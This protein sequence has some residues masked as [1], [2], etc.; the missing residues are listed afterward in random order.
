MF[1]NTFARVLGAAPVATP[2]NVPT[3][4]GELACR[5]PSV[6]Q[7]FQGGRRRVSIE[8]ARQSTRSR[9]SRLIKGGG[10]APSPTVKQKVSPDIFEELH[11]PFQ[12][13]A[14]G[15]KADLKQAA[16]QQIAQNTFPDQVSEYEPE[17]L[18]KT[19]D[20]L[21]ENPLRCSELIRHLSPERLYQFLLEHPSLA[22]H[23][24]ALYSL[25]ERTR[26]GQDTWLRKLGDA[27]VAINVMNTQG[28]L[29]TNGHGVFD[30]AS[31]YFYFYYSLQG[32]A[33]A[34][35]QMGAAFDSLKTFFSDHLQF[36]EAL[37]E[38]RTGKAAPQLN[39][40]AIFQMPPEW[41]LP[42]FTPATVSLET[43]IENPELE[44]MAEADDWILPKVNLLAEARD[45]DAEQIAQDVIERLTTI[46]EAGGRMSKYFFRGP[47]RLWVSA[48]TALGKTRKFSHSM[49]AAI[50]ASYV[51][52]VSVAGLEA[53]AIF[54]RAGN[55]NPETISKVNNRLEERARRILQ[56]AG[57]RV[58]ID[59][60][61]IQRE[62]DLEVL[63]ARQG[64]DILYG[65]AHTGV[66]DIP[67][68]F[69]LDG[70]V[71]MVARRVMG[72]TFPNSWVFKPA[73]MTLLD[74]PSDSASN[75]RYEKA[76]NRVMAMYQRLDG[77]EGRRPLEKETDFPM[78]TR[79]KV[80]GVGIF[81]MGQT[82]LVARN[83]RPG[84]KVE[85]IPLVK[86]T[87]PVG[88]DLV[89]PGQFEDIKRGAL[90]DDSL[91]LARTSYF[92]PMDFYQQYIAEFHD[93][94]P[95]KTESE[96]SA[97][98]R[99]LAQKMKDHEYRMMIRLMKEALTDLR[100]PDQ[101]E[102]FPEDL[103]SS[104]RKT[105]QDYLSRYKD[106]FHLYESG[107]RV[108]QNQIQESTRKYLA[109][110]TGPVNQALAEWC[111]HNKVGYL[112]VV[113]LYHFATTPV[114]EL[115]RWDG[116]GGVPAYLP[117]N[118]EAQVV[119]D[120]PDDQRQSSDLE[121]SI[122]FEVY[123]KDLKIKR[124]KE[125]HLDTV[126]WMQEQAVPLDLA[127][128]PI[129]TPKSEKAMHR[130]AARKSL[131]RFLDTFLKP[132]LF[133]ESENDLG[134]E[135]W[136]EEN[137]ISLDYFDRLV[138]RLPD[139]EIAGVFS[140]AGLNLYKPVKNSKE[141]SDRAVTAEHMRIQRT[142]LWLF[143]RV[144]KR[145]L[146]RLLRQKHESLVP[147]M[148]YHQT[149]MGGASFEELQQA[150]ARQ[151]ELDYSNAQTLIESQLA[152]QSDHFRTA[153]WPA[154]QQDLEA[155]NAPFQEAMRRFR[156]HYPSEAEPS[157]MAISEASQRLHQALIDANVFGDSS[158]P[159]Q[160]DSDL[161]LMTFYV[162]QALDRWQRR[163]EMRHQSD[164]SEAL[165]QQAQAD[166][167]RLLG[168]TVKYGYLN[169][170]HRR[171]AEKASK[172]ALKKIKDRAAE[173]ELLSEMLATGEVLDDSVDEHGKEKPGALTRAEKAYEKYSKRL[174]LKDRVNPYGSARTVLD[175]ARTRRDLLRSIAAYRDERGGI[176]LETIL[177]ERSGDH[178]IL[179]ED[180][181]L[182][183]VLGRL[184]QTRTSLD[185]LQAA[186]SEWED[187]WKPLIADFMDEMASLTEMHQEALVE[188]LKSDYQLQRARYQDLMARMRSE[189]I[190]TEE[191]E[192]RFQQAIHDY[193]LKYEALEVKMNAF[194]TGDFNQPKFNK[195]TL[196]YEKAWESLH[197]ATSDI[198]KLSGFSG[199]GKIR[200]FSAAFPNQADLMNRPASHNIEGL[201]PIFGTMSLELIQSLY[202]EIWGAADPR[203][204]G[205]IMAEWGLDGVAH[206]SAAVRVFGA[207]AYVGAFGQSTS[208][209]LLFEK[210]KS[211]LNPSQAQDYG[212]VPVTPALSL[213]HQ[214]F[215]D[216]LSMA[217]ISTLG[218]GQFHVVY[219]QT[220]FVG[221]I[222]GDA[223][224][225]GDAI[226][227]LRGGSN[228]SR[229]IPKHSG[230]G[231]APL[232]FDA[233]T[234]LI[235]SAPNPLGV[236]PYA[237]FMPREIVMS[238]SR[239]E[240]A[241]AQS[242]IQEPT[243]PTYQSV[244]GNVS[245]DIALSG[246]FLAGNLLEP[247]SN[248]TGAAS[249]RNRD[250]QLSLGNAFPSWLVADILSQREDSPVSERE[251][252]LQARR[253]MGALTE[254]GRWHAY[255]ETLSAADLAP[256]QEEPYE[257]ESPKELLGSS[258]SA[259]VASVLRRVHR[260]LAPVL[261]PMLDSVI[262]RR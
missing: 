26:N 49:T 141:F 104:A 38:H 86:V 166:F 234:R 181:G 52:E 145:S 108:P 136:L 3:W 124:A 89:V 142:G 113:Q 126:M 204:I 91:V 18:L 98:R 246:G 184:P 175:A 208:G 131:D 154:R 111:R 167:Y 139:S 183:D 125:V 195:L 236:G 55:E 257:Y 243:I 209:K 59:P 6:V 214:G 221:P 192:L 73:K 201:E 101:A 220:N 255:T 75:D 58:Y 199:A 116:Q 180:F 57:G 34:T 237:P 203:V 248:H 4:T 130:A 244:P 56:T 132:L 42:H 117:L 224:W 109:G 71:R 41:V 179:S 119:P 65:M 103:K 182:S 60:T 188:T 155:A 233:G 36:V 215:H 67:F 245:P 110:V 161:R 128:N 177:Q 252:R 147:E 198:A 107:E 40:D 31:D 33:R 97:L 194:L 205:R 92:D 149:A 43:K 35:D 82:R 90:T 8:P 137:G 1:Q 100:A 197:R 143:R 102:G 216:Y 23:R 9:L 239:A 231:V 219:E 225:H 242:L 28:N 95:P 189:A 163:S 173:I 217:A 80:G 247:F 88:L 226:G 186:K 187:Q 169:E 253:Y 20:V 193:R 164:Q 44:R 46:N 48:R 22:T 2:V 47:A 50:A 30:V 241:F 61:S 211:I 162:L 249:L 12:E 13:E 212:V 17:L 94:R 106:A 150:Y 76:M 66:G 81:Y 77:I 32:A 37:Y 200:A 218:L 258:R 159:V 15:V 85:D 64:R 7:Q 238:A 84:F 29:T 240:T 140:R 260:R 93:N 168:R 256:S 96:W 14:D 196:Y 45:V 25:I 10:L 206:L 127:T 129:K 70:Q 251:R 172:D 210:G 262:G 39:E 158:W 63:A 21:S 151:H 123:K 78:G 254:I 54:W 74:R 134:L 72:A 112:D 185:D 146:K 153:V 122:L 156:E 24:D 165:Y 229:I 160:V 138:N 120:I 79:S 16:Y 261:T 53:H 51:Y 235:T 148:S 259:P 176:D 228:L 202:A 114:Q 118:D 133:L 230:K 191:M 152:W 83:F 87:S 232:V 170:Y 135:T 178:W 207:Q 69:M 144:A 213:N 105:Y 222:L 227:M 223:L 19:A 62:V 5:Q 68:G 250:T 190:V 27:F 174:S 121:T 171:E 157:Y 115:D 11:Y 99:S